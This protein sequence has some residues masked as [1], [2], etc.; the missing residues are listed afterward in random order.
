MK[1]L[2]EWVPIRRGEGTIT[3]IMF[4]YIFGA[5]TSYYILKPLRSGLFLTKFQSSDLAY[6]YWLSAAFAGTLATPIFRLGRKVSAIT[7]ITAT[8]A[9][10]IVTLLYF[11]WAMGRPIR[12]LPYIY[13]VYVQVAPVLLVAQFWLLAGYIYDNRQAKRLY[14]LLGAGASG[15]ALAGSFLVRMLRAP[16]GTGLLLMI[17]G[18]ISLGLIGLSFLA[19]RY[20]RKDPLIASEQKKF[21]TE[22]EKPMELLQMVFGSRH[23]L[24]MVAFILLIMIA[25]QLAD[26]QINDA[27]QRTFSGSPESHARIDEFMATFNFYTNIIGILLQI[28]AT[29]LIVRRFGIWAATLFLP[30]AVLG[31]S[32]GVFIAPTLLMTVFVEGSDS[33]F[34]YSLN[35][36]GLELLYMPLSPDVRKKVKLFIDVFIDRV[37]RALAGVIIVAVTSKYLHLGLRGTS[38]AIIL[39]S[40]AAIYVCV[41]LRNSYLAA[42]RQQLTRR[43]LDLSEVNRFVTDPASVRLLL[44]TLEGN[45]ERQILY[46]LRLLQSSSGVDFSSQLLPLLQHESPNVRQETLRTLETLPPN[47]SRPVRPL[48]EDPDKGV[49]RAAVDYLCSNGPESG[50][51]SVQSMLQHP[52]SE[53][54]LAVADWIAEHETGKVMPTIDFVKELMGN[55]GPESAAARATAAKLAVRLTRAEMVQVLRELMDDP[56]SEVRQAAIRAAGVAADPDLLLDVIKSLTRR[57]LR[58]AA[59][60]SLLMY[61][62]HVVGTLGDILGDPRRELPLRREIPWLLGRIHSR[63]A[64]S[65]LVDQLEVKDPLLKYRVVKALN[66]L[67]AQVP[68]LPQ[69]NPAIAG[70]IYAQTRSYY[71]A[72]VLWQAFEPGGKSDG[73][74][75]V[76]RALKERLDQNLEIIFRLLGLQYPQ[77]DIYS[78][79]NALRGN[80]AD[81]RASALEFLDNLLHKNLK[82]IILPLLEEPSA[83]RL[84]SR[85]SDLFGIQTMGRNEALRI[86]L[87]QP[88]V[89]LRACALHEIG[90][91]CLKDLMDECRNLSQDS[92]PLVRETA[93]WALQRCA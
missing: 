87:R 4:L 9:M 77:N 12:I 25:S 17:C 5:L 91:G 73:S 61:G 31:S 93:Q 2:S 45:Q 26:W 40:G 37:G 36:A 13:Y 62:P 83:E 30:T 1:W 21:G 79:Y 66:R 49:R 63:N 38:V 50:E 60:E 88:D 27:V 48:L 35:R 43:E 14:G 65:L 92:E 44:G 47:H 76:Q 55:S 68:D 7:L 20:R 15:G 58:P 16:L 84:I 85:A 34:R 33:V 41:E 90:R 89:W 23:L 78:A 53:I 10:M 24:L 22:K 74:A 52:S 32:I 3:S 75:L 70:H 57:E 46:A 80:R 86:I 67:H 72:L 28:L 8:N 64:A 69:A 59:R 54:R 18:I 56:V 6:A 71:E 29:S 11:G 51:G 39:L 19:W 82:T 42:F 81:R